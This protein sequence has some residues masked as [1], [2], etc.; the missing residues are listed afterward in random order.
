V[1]TATTSTA[2]PAN[3][4][5]NAVCGDGIVGPGE[6][7]DGDADMDDGCL[8]T[9]AA[10]CGGI[11]FAGVEQCDGNTT[12]D[13]CDSAASTSRPAVPCA[14]MERSNRARNATTA[15]RP[16][17]TLRPAATMKNRRYLRR[18]LRQPKS[19]AEVRLR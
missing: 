2:T 14:A 12:G 9:A 16:T 8:T 7:C 18:H 15:T 5:T 6:T 13:G 17:A 4:C 1:T 19:R 11:V 3:N 10:A